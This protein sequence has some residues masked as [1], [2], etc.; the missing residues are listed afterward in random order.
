MLRCLER[1][2]FQTYSGVLDFEAY[3]ARVLYPWVEQVITEDESYAA[4]DDEADVSEEK[5]AAGR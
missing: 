5:E 4:Q 1:I 3:K 2:A